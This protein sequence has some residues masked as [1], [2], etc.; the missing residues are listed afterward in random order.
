MQ[1]LSAHVRE[2]GPD[3]QLSPA[4]SLCGWMVVDRSGETVGSIADL[5]LDLDCGRVAYAVVASGGFVGVGEKIFAV[6]WSALKS[7]GRHFVLQASRTAL[8]SGPALDPEHW[9]AKPAKWWHEQVHAHFHSRPY[10]E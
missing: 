4:A 6:P 10:W 2:G 7:V 8:D 3:Q 9:P 5:M 1:P